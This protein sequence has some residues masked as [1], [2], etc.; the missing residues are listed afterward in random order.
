MEYFSDRENGPKARVNEIISPQV[1]GGI[2]AVIQSAV[3]SGSFGNAF[4]DNCPDGHGSVGSDEATMVRVLRAEIPEVEWPLSDTKEVDQGFYSTS[5]EPHAPPTAVVLDLLEFC[6]RNIAKPIQGSFHSYFGHHHLT[7]DVP[8]GQF[9]FRSAVNRIF[10]RN[11]IAYELTSEGQIQ[12]LA[13][14]V[15]RESLASGQFATGDTQLDRMLEEARA[16]FFS[17]RLD[18]RKIALERLWDCWERIKSLEDPNNKRLSVAK[19]LDRASSEP[20]FRA[21]LEKEARELTEIGNTFH[22]RHSEVTQQPLNNEHH[23]DYLFH[24]MYSMLTLL[25]RGK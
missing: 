7:F 2:V 9:D 23:I 14:P 3:A 10:S 22:I 5:R 20:G 24:R 17:P 12:R 1:W 16:R 4:P 6:H 25:L 21:S 11:G 8:T 18:E 19:L 13:P 15:L